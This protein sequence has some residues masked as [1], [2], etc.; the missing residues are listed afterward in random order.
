MKQNIRLLLVVILILINTN[1]VQAQMNQDYKNT[2]HKIIITFPDSWQLI[3]RPTQPGYLALSAR[4]SKQF[5]V[6]TLVSGPHKETDKSN[7]QSETTPSKISS[8]SKIE[9]QGE[10]TIDGVKAKWVLSS[11]T[12]LPI[13]TYSLTY[14]IL[15]EHDDYVIAMQG[16]YSNY[17]NDRK[18]FDEIVSTIKFLD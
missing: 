7:T 11:H 9:D 10:T 1:L 8:I 17:E 12:L 4:S 2:D 3:E 14:F 13:R 15:T 16:A 18:V 5:P 6:I